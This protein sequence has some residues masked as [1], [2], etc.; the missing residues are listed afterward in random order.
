MYGMLSEKVVGKHDKT[1][2]QKE[3]S[4]RVTVKLFS[5]KKAG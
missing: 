3:L 4:N 5:G 1:I 2:T